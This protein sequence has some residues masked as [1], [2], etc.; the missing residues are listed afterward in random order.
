MAV[1][2]SVITPSIRKEGLKLVE[3]ALKRQTLDEYEWIV[4]DKRYEGGV[5]GLGRAY[6]DLIRQAKGELIVSW[7]DYTFANP[8]CLSRFWNCYEKN[9]NSIVSAV[10]NKYKDDSFMV[11]TWQDPRQR[12]DQGTFYECYP[13]DIEANLCAVPKQAF[14][15]VGGFDEEMD[16]IAYGFDARGVFERL[17]MVDGYKFYLDQAN[18]S[19]SLEHDRPK[20]WDKNNFILTWLDYK[21][22]NIEKGRYPALDYLKR[23]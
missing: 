1:L 18:E 12:S 6:N 11:K 4:N 15:D 22:K 5:W 14:Y 23:A 10:G 7:Q 13:W 19:F 17:D 2:I 20:D 21:A 3:K 9:P 8:D 16:F